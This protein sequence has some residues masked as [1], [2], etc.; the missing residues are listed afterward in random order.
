MNEPQVVPW[1]VPPEILKRA[2]SLLKNNGGALSWHRSVLE[3]VIAQ[4]AERASPQTVPAGLSGEQLEAAMQQA[5][6]PPSLVAP[7]I[8]A[9]LRDFARVLASQSQAVPPGSEPA[10][11]YEP[12]PPE[13][14]SWSVTVQ[15]NGVDALTIHDEGYCGLTDVERYAA[16]VRRAA[17]HLRSFIGKP[18]AEALSSDE[19]ETRAD[20]PKEPPPIKETR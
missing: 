1:V 15:V 16:V 19:Q 12:L 4:G 18:A 3:W 5:D 13:V 6:W 14:H 11:E 10:D 20:P 7:V 17:T 9:K 8:K 2:K